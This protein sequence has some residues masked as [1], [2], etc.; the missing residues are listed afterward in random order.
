M[1]EKRLELYNGKDASQM[2]IAGIAYTE[3]LT[4]EFAQNDEMPTAEMTQSMERI[5]AIAKNELCQLEFAAA[6]K[7]T[8]LRFFRMAS[9][10]AVLLLFVVPLSLFSISASRQEIANYMIE[11]FDKYSVIQYDTNANAIKP[12][13]WNSEFYPLWIP[14]GFKYFEVVFFDNLKYIQYDSKSGKEFSFSVYENSYVP[15]FDSEEYLFE[16]IHINGCNAQLLTSIDGTE[17]VVLIP[18]S[19]KTFVIS[20]E[21]SESNILKIA[22]NIKN[23]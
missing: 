11:N 9:T 19:S 8:K 17:H 7:R 14:E 1:S 16:E 18:I 4:R 12:I 23:M 10:A 22:E 3:F 15:W 2:R 5:S 21:L 6:K 20:G 13:G